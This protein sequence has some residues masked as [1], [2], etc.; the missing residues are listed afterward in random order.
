MAVRFRT[1]HMP[2]Y[3]LDAY[4]AGPVR[5]V[6]GRIVSGPPDTRRAAFHVSVAH[7]GEPAYRRVADEAGTCVESSLSEF[8]T[9]IAMRVGRRSRRPVVL[10]I[11]LAASITAAAASVWLSAA[12]AVATLIFAI[13]VRSDDAA[14]RTIFVLYSL[15]EESEALYEGVANGVA[16]LARSQSRSSS[17]GPV[18]VEVAAAPITTNV[19]PPEL[20][21]GPMR[22]QFLP[23]GALILHEKSV[24]FVSY[25]QVKVEAS[26]SRSLHYGTP[27]SDSPRVGQQWQYQRKDGSPDRRHK[28]NPLLPIVETGQLTISAAGVLNESISVSNPVAAE[29]FRD[30]FLAIGKPKPTTHPPSMRVVAPVV[31]TLRPNS[32]TVVSPSVISSTNP[33]TAIRAI[34]PD[35][36]PAATTASNAAVPPAR[37][38]KVEELARVLIRA[39]TTL[40]VDKPAESAKRPTLLDGNALWIPPCRGVTVHGFEIGG[41][42]YVGQRLRGLDIHFGEPALI[43]PSLSIDRWNMAVPSDGQIGYS[44]SYERL[45]PPFRAAFLN[46]LASGRKDPAAP[47][48]F[49]FLFFYGLERRAFEYLAGKGSDSAECV[50]IARELER[51]LS[52]YQHDSFGLYAS[53]LLDLLSA[54]EPELIAPSRGDHLR[55]GDV[56]PF[57]TRVTLGKLAS[58]GATLPAGLALEWL[59]SGGRASRTPAARCPAEFEKLFAIRYTEQFAGGMRLHAN[60]TSLIVRH[61]P[62]SSALRERSLKVEGLPD[63]T[64][65]TKPLSEF[66]KIAD[67]CC[68]ELDS[69][70]RWVAK[71]PQS[72]HSL[73]AISMLPAELMLV[74]DSDDIR[75]LTSFLANRLGNVEYVSIAADDLLFY[76]PVANPLKLTKGEAVQLAQALEKIGYSMEPD[77]RFGGHPPASGSSIIIFRRVPDAPAVASPEYAAALV[78]ARLGVAIAN[79]DGVFTPGERNALHRSIADAFELH[80]AERRRLD[81]HVEWLSRENLGTTGVKKQIAA[82]APEQRAKVGG[83]VTRI[84]AADGAV[85]AAAMRSLEKLYR[86]LGLTADDLYRSVHTVMTNDGEQA[87]AP[88]TQSRGVG[89]D[90]MRVQTKLA[91]TATV[92]SLLADVFAEED[93][94]QVTSSVD[95]YTATPSGVGGLDAAQSAFLRGLIARGEWPR[96][97]VELLASEHALLVDGALEAVNDYAFEHCGDPVWEGDDPIIINDYVAKEI[98]A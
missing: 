46:W 34:I 40:R 67:L 43:D 71:N 74:V 53:S 36:T 92:S 88:Q 86:S 28:Y 23:D 80:D 33:L 25:G 68:D 17:R 5:T 7:N 6:H 59:R 30:A 41:F 85:D 79:A 57:T 19:T 55:P 15:T 73:A 51:L 56:L 98:L 22:V 13:V 75:T 44:P 35:G 78:L 48:G 62:A 10:I 95:A 29:H 47:I 12:I 54:R 65:L 2:I 42:V 69:Y 21:L 50:A 76:W 94:A 91:Q 70:S 3:Q 11:G 63:V 31:Q 20:L 89:L 96:H 24:W 52:I 18:T 82:L 90:M 49:V 37:A 45:T 14:R 8:M 32:P 81:A 64:A 84:A 4:G 9:E 83:Y 61:T 38:V 93:E 39:E 77:V 16:W 26:R 87:P 60:K 66:E 27:S 1:T 72:A 58:A 97:D